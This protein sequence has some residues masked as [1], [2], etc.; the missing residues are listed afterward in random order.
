LKHALALPQ[1]ELHIILVGVM[2]TIYECHTELSSSKFG[3]DRCK[4]EELTL[5]THLIQYA[6]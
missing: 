6:T 1:S 3:L 5:T 2:G 4:V